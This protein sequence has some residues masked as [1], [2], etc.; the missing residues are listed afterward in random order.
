MELGLN[1]IERE[2]D[3]NIAKV[4]EKKPEMVR[5]FQNHPRKPEFIRNLTKELYHAHHRD[6]LKS[7]PEVTHKAIK[8]MTKTFCKV[9]LE[10]MEQSN[11]SQ[12]EKNRR[13][14]ESE[15]FKNA[16]SIVREALPDLDVDNFKVKE[17]DN[18]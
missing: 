6:V 12:A 1:P 15:R 8:E 16:E 5:F 17:L 7:G 10:H 11:L 13:R 3:R 4:F 9:A 2:V 14:D 18:G